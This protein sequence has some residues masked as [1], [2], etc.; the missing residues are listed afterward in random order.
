MSIDPTISPTSRASGEV[1]ARLQAI[2]AERASEG[3]AEKLLSLRTFIDNDLRQVEEDL[4]AIE[5]KETPLHRS[6]HH[7]IAM[8][9]KRLRPMCVALAARVGHG[10]SDGARAMAVAVEVVHNATLLHDDVVDVGDVRRGAPAARV[11]FGNAA[12][13][14]AGDWLLVDALDRIQRAGHPALLIRMISTLKEM[15]D[16]ES[17]QLANRGSMRGSVADYFRV[18]EGKTASLF[19]WG[20]YAGAIAG[21]VS[22]EHAEALERF[23]RKVGV[24]FQLVDDLLDV[25]GD[26]AHVGKTVFSDLREGKS[27]YPLLLA[28]ERD[29]DLAAMIERS[30]GDSLALDPEL[31]RLAARALRDGDVLDRCRALALKLTTEALVELHSLP[32]SQARDALEGMA[33]ALL[34]RSK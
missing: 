27:T 34:H 8:G 30:M 32:P 6:V 3:L 28:V 13:I 5:R 11:I 1:M 12:S 20:L 9:G 2:A 4:A 33:I 22:V 26:A 10:F 23:G 17:L 21:G 15:L 31:E 18:V 7:L 25:G 14:F 19:G 16:A 24:C 29:P